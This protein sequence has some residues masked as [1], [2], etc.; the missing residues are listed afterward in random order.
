M[1]N[2]EFASLGACLAAKGSQGQSL[3]SS[4]GQSLPSSQG[5]QGQR[6]PSSQGSQGSQGQSLPSS[7][8][9]QGAQG[10][11]GG[12]RRAAPVGV[13]RA[14]SKGIWRLGVHPKGR[15]L[16]IGTGTKGNLVIPQNK[17]W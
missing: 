14:A 1:D 16:K 12:G 6:L 2:K 9:S 10:S 11:R 7:Q 15:H 3:P 8:D 5:S 4:Q 17:N 13:W